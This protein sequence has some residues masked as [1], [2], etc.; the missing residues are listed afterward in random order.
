VEP[1]VVEAFDVWALVDAALVDAAPVEPVVRAADVDPF[2]AAES[3]LDD[4]NALPWFEA[5]SP[6]LPHAGASDATER[7]AT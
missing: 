7:T 5:A 4:A 3:P 1:A 6:E 2:D